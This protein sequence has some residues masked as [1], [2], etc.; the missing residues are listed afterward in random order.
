MVAQV[1]AQARSQVRS[2]DAPA[3]PAPSAQQLFSD[4]QL[5]GRT[6]AGDSSGYNLG[7]RF[8][9]AV[10]GT[11]R[12]VK[13]A[14]P[15]GAVQTLRRAAIYSTAGTLLRQGS[16][17]EMQAEPAAGN[18]VE[19]SLDTPLAVV[20]GITYIAQV[21][22]NPSA[23]GGYSAQA[24]GFASP[25]VNG[26][27]TA[28]ADGADGNGTFN[29]SSGVTVQF[30][31]TDGSA[32]YWVT[33]VFV[34]GAAPSL[35]TGYPNENNTGTEAGKPAYGGPLTISTPGTI[36]EDVTITGGLIVTAANVIIRR[37]IINHTDAFGVDGDGATDLTVE[38]CT[39]TGPGVGGAANASI[40]G[41]GTFRRNKCS[42]SENGI[43]IGAGASTVTDNYVFDLRTNAAVPHYDGITCQGAQDGVLIQH[44]TV[45]GTD[46]SC[47]FIKDDFGA[48]TNVTVDDNLLLPDATLGAPAFMIAIDIVT[49]IT[50]VSV[51]GNKLVRGADGYFADESSATVT[52]NVNAYTG[53]PV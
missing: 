49:S 23:T 7:V 51:T 10:N 40:L 13:F 53:I 52:G 9:P 17:G 21:T 6:S 25:V 48:I 1:R 42:G 35:P 12:A 37:S 44:N 22:V 38:D 47:I 20:A 5:T 2:D 8:V 24:N 33:P 43:V 45:V 18:V 14:K 50:G 36:V 26:D 28:P 41:Q 32:N 29:D 3:P 11:V 46:T 34:P 30:A 31:S 19:V 16:R 27:L 4:A 15:T 39:I